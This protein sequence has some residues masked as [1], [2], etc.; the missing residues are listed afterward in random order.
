[1]PEDAQPNDLR[2]RSVVPSIPLIRPARGIIPP[3]DRFS[4]F[5]RP[6]FKRP[7]DRPH[8]AASPK[9]KRKLDQLQDRKEIVCKLPPACQ[10]GQNGCN[11][12]RKEFVVDETERLRKRGLK[13]FGHS[14]QD[15]AVHFLCTQED[16]LNCFLTPISPIK[17][18]QKERRQPRVEQLSQLVPPPNP[19]IS[20]VPGPPRIFKSGTLCFSAE[21]SVTVE[22]TEERVVSN[23]P[24]GA[25]D[26]DLDQ[27][28]PV[29]ELMFGKRGLP[30]Q[31]PSIS[32]A[33]VSA[34]APTISSASNLG[35]RTAKPVPVLPGSIVTVSSVSLQPTVAAATLPL[36][37]QPT[38]SAALLAPPPSLPK[39]G[40]TDK[41]PLEG[42]TSSTTSPHIPPPSHDFELSLSDDCYAC[43][44][45]GEEFRIPFRTPQDKLRRFLSSSSPVSSLIVSMHGTLEGVDV[46][47]RKHWLITTGPIP[48]KEA[49]DDACIVAAGNRTVVILGHSRDNQQLSL[50][51]TDNLGGNAVSVL[52]PKRP[53]NPA[54]KGGASAVAPMMQPLMFASGGYDHCVHLWS[55]KEDLSSASP[56]AVAFKHN[57]QIQ[58]LLAIR[59]TSHKL[60]SAGADCNVHYWDLSS[61]R[62]VNTLKPSN[63]VYHVHSTASPFCTLLEVAHRE[64]QFEIRDHRYVSIIPVQRFGYTT[65]Q[66]HGRFMKGSFMSN[67]FASGDRDGCVRLWDLRNVKKPCAE[68][69]CFNGL[70]ISQ[71]V[72]QSSRLLA[73]AE[74]NQIRLVKYRSN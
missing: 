25:F 63:S 7:P 1:M 47:S 29:A 55:I 32:A 30:K 73:C 38:S 4:T 37:P 62:V 67:C 18:T 9:K 2:G 13:V 39:V 5:G 44:P 33:C 49:V 64:Q 50:I 57:S 22:S 70:K 20:T 66:V 48:T 27:S 69:R 43:E 23:R 15:G 53:W 11:A 65:P 28:V 19:F 17:R 59:D 24:S 21:P 68:I 36:P 26:F 41:L 35:S 14:F 56:Q 58:S 61:E 6:S 3:S 31:T 16:L 71:L 12:K 42:S 40:I 46:V 45:D 8:P 60:I 74:N 51:N 54:K 52:D 72:F 10:K 34:R